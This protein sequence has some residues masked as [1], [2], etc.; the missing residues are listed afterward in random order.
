M[1]IG[2]KLLSLSARKL[3]T[4]L[5]PDLEALRRDDAVLTALMV[6]ESPRQ[7]QRPEPTAQVHHFNALCSLH[8]AL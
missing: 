6:Q 7:W 5:I 8:S 3:E 4:E 1:S 2:L